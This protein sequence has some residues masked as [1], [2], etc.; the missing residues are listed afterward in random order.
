M[1]APHESWPEIER[2]LDAALDLDPSARRAFLDRECSDPD[3]RAHI[4]L[5]L[6][7]A[8]AAGSFLDRPAQELAAGLVREMVEETQQAAGPRPPFE[9]VGPYRLIRE[10]GRGGMGAVYLAERA[11]DEFRRQVAIKLV[12]PAAAPDLTARFLAERQ[13]LASL[14]HPNIAR[15]Y[16]GGTTEDGTPYL[17]MERID[18]ERIDV[19]CDRHRLTVAQRLELFLTVCDAVQFAHQSMVVHRDLKP[20]NV[21][22]AAEGTVKLLDFGVAKLLGSDFAAPDLTRTGL[23]PMTPAYASP[24]QLRG[25]PISTATDVYALG[26]LLFEL[27]TG[28]APY[29]VSG[30][31]PSEIE[32]VV[33]EQQPARP[34]TAVIP[35]APAAE[36]SAAARSTTPQ[37]LSRRLQGDLDNIVLTALR[38]EPQHR[39]RSVQQLRDDVR[40]HLDGLPVSARAPTPTY[41]AAKF[42][43]RNRIAVGAAAIILLSLVGGLAGTT[44][45]AR[46]AAR[47]ARRATEVRDF[48]AGLFESSDPDSTRGRTVTALELL[49]RGAARLDSGLTAEPALRADMLGVVGRIY[50]DLGQHDHAR[51]LLEEALRIREGPAGGSAEDRAGSAGDLAAV[52]LEQGEF[53]D[54]ERYAREALAVRRGRASRQPA[55]LAAGL[56]DLA[57]IVSSRGD[58]ESADSLYREALDI[59]ARTGDRAAQ[60]THLDGH[61]IALWRAARYEE[62]QR[63]LEESLAMRRALFGAE[64]TL[65][66]TSLLNLSAT[67]LER[68]D[69]ARVEQLL[70]ECLA[71]RR[72]LLGDA[73]PHVAVVF[74][75]LGAMFTR[76]GRLDEAESAHRQALATHRAAFGDAHPDVANSMNHLGV[77]LYY[78]GHFREAAATFEEVLPLW[79]AAFGAHH[80]NVFAVLNNLGA[81]RRQAGDLD[82]AEQVLRTTLALRRE[83]FGEE[84]ADVAQSLNN[85]A[86]LLVQRGRHVEADSMFRHAIA[87]WRRTLGDDNPAVADGL[88][89]LGRLLLLQSRYA[90]AEPVLREAVRIR[91]SA[92]DPQAALL[93]SAR[94][95]HAETLIP[96]GNPSAADSLVALALPVLAQ[97]WGED[98]DLT[99]RARKAASD[100]ATARSRPPD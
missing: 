47:E 62:S 44:W 36:S 19:H 7:S 74:N 33:G 72:K 66:A 58:A 25:G 18:G 8:D 89:E 30:R 23:V 51:P 82:A 85:L 22:V 73:H 4:E 41:L 38:K 40:R 6:R 97:R 2:L 45:Q 90:D 61:G 52:L 34:S 93:A 14:D 94:L 46:V 9:R 54:A 87:V 63:A 70:T 98:H 95:H 3:L 80:R 28:H 17:V 49:D 60:A 100:I 15:L 26:V 83:A 20:S 50:M 92:L 88:V 81:A 31:T 35:P 43:R 24:E 67:V 76:A 96:L 53:E 48:L 79:R 5:L 91:T 55:A 10:I 42:V 56:S 1:S 65:V 75:N 37:T 86:L 21:I 12:Q 13:I 32:R 29:D 16:D 78:R 59:D 57:S 84:H 39:Y 64:H 27:L 71:I 99:R 77:V 68:G 69:Y 11:D